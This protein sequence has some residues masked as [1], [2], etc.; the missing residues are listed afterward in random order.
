MSRRIGQMPNLSCG[1]PVVQEENVGAEKNL[2]V[3]RRQQAA[4]PQAAA[5]TTD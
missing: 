1:F 3:P 2:A 4:Q 5:G